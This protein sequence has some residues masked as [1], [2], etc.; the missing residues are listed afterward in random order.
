M[1]GISISNLSKKRNRYDYPTI[2]VY[3]GSRIAYVLDS[4]DLN[5]DLIEIVWKEYKH[6]L[7]IIEEN[8]RTLPFLVTLIILG[9][10][11]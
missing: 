1:L 3:K 4:V 6:R 2:D 11:V 8:H 10:G 7:E 5:I 9:I